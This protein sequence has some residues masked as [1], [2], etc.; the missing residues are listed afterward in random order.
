MIKTKPREREL[1]FPHDYLID[2][3]PLSMVEQT[4][5]QKVALAEAEECLEQRRREWECLS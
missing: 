1:D 4:P 5:E 3:F 2:K